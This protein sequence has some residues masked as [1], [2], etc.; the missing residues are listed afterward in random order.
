MDL[1]FVE[2]LATDFGGRVR[3]LNSICGKKLWSHQLAEFWNNAIVALDG[4]DL[5]GGSEQRRLERE[6]MLLAPESSFADSAYHRWIGD[7]RARES[8]PGIVYLVISCEKY[9]SRAL[10]LHQQLT[11][12]L[13]PAF[14]V[15]GTES[16][17]E[18]LCDDRYLTVP[19]PDNYE[20]LTI[21]VLESLVAVRRKFGAVS[22]VK[23]D[24]DSR[25]IGPPDHAK[26]AELVAS[27][28]YAGWI[29]AGDT[30]F[31]D[32]C[33][34][35]G[36]CEVLDDEPYRK[37]F[38]GEWIGGPAYYLGPTAVEHLVRD[39][40]SYPGEFYGEIFEDKAIGD[41]LRA[42]GITMHRTDLPTMLGLDVQPGSS[43]PSLPSLT[44]P[45][46]STAPNPFSR[47]HWDAFFSCR[48][49]P[50]DYTNP[51]EALKYRQ[52]L[53]LLPPGPFRQALE[54]GCAEGHFTIELAPRAH[55]LIASD[56]SPIAV[57][58][59]RHRCDA[60]GNVDCRVLDFTSD[61][62]PSGNDLIVCSEAL[63]YADPG[64]LCA[65]ASKFANALS[66]GGLLV[67]AHAHLIADER[68]RTG[69]D[70][71]A[72][73]RFGVATVST[74]FTQTAELALV[75]ELRTELYRIQLFRRIEPGTEI[76]PAI[77]EQADF[78]RN[79]PAHVERSIIWGGATIT[80]AEAR[81]REQAGEV[82]I[83]MYHSISDDGPPELAPY[84]VTPVA[85]K[86]QLR[87]LR[88]NGYH[89]ITLGEWASHL[90]LRQPV[91]GRPIVI[92]FDDGYKSF[93]TH[94]W[95][96]LKAADLSA[97]MFVV[98][99]KVGSVADWDQ[100]SAAPLEL[101]TWDELRLL[102]EEGLEIGGHSTSHRNLLELTDDEIVA[103]S[104]EVRTSLREEL[105]V[106]ATSI[107]FPWGMNDG[108]VRKALSRAG[109]RIAA[110][111]NAGVSR[112]GDDPMN[113]PRIEIFGDDDIDTFVRRVRGV[114][115]RE[116]QA[117]AD[118]GA[119]THAHA[120]SSPAS[121]KPFVLGSDEEPVMDTE[122][123]RRLATRIG[124]LIDGLNAIR[125]ELLS[126]ASASTKIQTTLL[127]L[128]NAPVTNK[129]SQR[130]EP[131]QKL[132]PGVL[133]GFE[134]DATVNLTVEPK[135]DQTVSPPECL[136]TL[137]LDYSGTSR[138]LTLEADAVWSE[139]AI[140][141][142]YQLT[143]CAE[144]D[145]RVDCLAKL[146]LHRKEGG[147]HDLT[148]SEFDLQPGLKTAR[149]SG[150]LKLPDLTEYDTTRPPRLLI[151]FDTKRDMKLEF[152]YINLYFA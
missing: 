61:E 138:F 53:D 127:G 132:A 43:P 133:I 105:G 118:V 146:R 145:R 12:G 74:A 85:F 29:I 63:Y 79:L 38:R 4:T 68:D 56:I 147:F 37:R 99:G 72:D 8:G 115:N 60:L 149:Q 100:T 121:L 1:D 70:W 93:F 131:Y 101:M 109:F 108:R 125:T 28:D 113:L 97:T 152:N 151:F 102:K 34:H 136:N 144:P 57:Q 9:R 54:L 143:V 84:R 114:G 30:R 11:K 117:Q 41:T 44:R 142:R 21:K 110:S 31:F 69:F 140:A 7:D 35:A 77:I 122:Y 89:S 40:L 123:T 2:F 82:P 87:W 42:H 94:A 5:A 58:R 76:E 25:Y 65:L 48:E 13:Q 116:R 39:Y 71:G 24:D 36:K 64:Q 78:S 96:L 139:I 3:F 120:S 128:F 103:D 88:S 81:V 55:H 111:T 50:W 27:T 90:A 91:P 134:R 141:E 119:T 45:P 67:M 106:E 6:L 26:I 18:A 33:W 47:G 14:V 62:L 23:I 137:N 16:A 83:L 126:I 95:P 73:H 124:S 59:T 49:D 112:F 75:R 19:A 104:L 17:E 86:D 107:A 20:S 148:F 46:A 150:A 135:L 15:L 98:T 52:T 51:Y 22:V 92:T 32:R 129:E 130:V 10:Q 66:V 80:R